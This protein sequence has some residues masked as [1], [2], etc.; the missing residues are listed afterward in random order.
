MSKP[1]GKDIILR[2]EQYLVEQGKSLDDRLQS[3]RL[4]VGTEEIIAA[5]RAKRVI[6]DRALG[7]FKIGEIVKEVLDWNENVDQ[8]IRDAKKALLLSNYLERTDEN[9]DAIADLKNLLLSAPGNTLFNKILQILDANPPDPL[10]VEH[11]ATA[12]EHIVETDFESLFEEHKY[13]LAQ[14]GQLT[15]QALAILADR[16]SWPLIELNTSTST[17]SRVTSDWLFE[18]TSAYAD[19]KKIIDPKYQARIRFSINEL[20]TTRMMEAHL[21]EN[22]LTKCTVTQMGQM[23]IPYISKPHNAD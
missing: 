19:S 11:L 7:L 22:G 6:R 2:P 4:P 13:A 21:V 18:F 14:I 8:E 23:L 10:L 12:L 16:K 17:G 1:T 3:V 20:T 9:T 15:P 5:G